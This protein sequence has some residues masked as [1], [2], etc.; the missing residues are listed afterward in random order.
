MSFR[1]DDGNNIKANSLGGSIKPQKPQKPQKSN[2][3]PVGVNQFATFP[4]E[5]LTIAKELIEGRLAAIKANLQKNNNP[6]KIK[7]LQKEIE[8]LAKDLKA[9]TQE[10]NKRTEP[11]KTLNTKI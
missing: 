11:Q 3:V 7:E 10:L 6:E 5:E 9:I 1:I 2:N 8:Q 4:T